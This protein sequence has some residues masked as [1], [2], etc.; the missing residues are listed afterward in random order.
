M[1]I[2]SGGQQAA[3]L[4]SARLV[5]APPPD[6]GEAGVSS[7][8][9]WP[10]TATA[11]RDILLHDLPCRRRWLRH[12][13][14]SRSEPPNQAAVAWVLALTLW[15]RGEVSESRHTLPRSLKDRVSR[16]LSGQL[17]SASTLALFIEAFQMSAEQE[18]RLYAAWEEDSGGGAAEG[19]PVDGQVVRLHG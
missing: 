16:A 8:P 14:R 3:P 6:P 17:V 4:P 13:R 18:A 2:S 12:A 9:A 15:E 10:E 7:G 5:P 11:L 1:A 19:A